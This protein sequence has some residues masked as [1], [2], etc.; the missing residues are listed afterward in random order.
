MGVST[1]LDSKVGN[2]RYCTK[3]KLQ[4]KVPMMDFGK[5]T[6]NIQ[7]QAKV[8]IQGCVSSPAA[9]AGSRHLGIE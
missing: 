5:Q 7:G 9:E 3:E 8:G 2:E 4:A 6:R 1:R